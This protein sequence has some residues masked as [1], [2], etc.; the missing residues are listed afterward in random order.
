LERLRSQ[1]IIGRHL[2]GLLARTSNRGKLDRGAVLARGVAFGNERWA[3]ES[4]IA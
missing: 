4:P 3:G 2:P 1:E